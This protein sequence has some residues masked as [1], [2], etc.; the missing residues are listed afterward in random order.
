[1]QSKGGLTP[2]KAANAL[3]IYGITFK[4][5]HLNDEHRNYLGKYC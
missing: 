4:T 2:S 3:E 5:I 1:M